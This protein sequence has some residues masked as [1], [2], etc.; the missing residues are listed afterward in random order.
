MTGAFSI[1]VADGSAQRL[2]AWLGQRVSPCAQHIPALKVRID[3]PVA[4][5][6]LS[7]KAMR[8]RPGTAARVFAAIARAGVNVLAIAQSSDEERIAVCL[9]D[10]KHARAVLALRAEACSVG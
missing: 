10:A 3:A 2:E 7:S 1:V 9:A 4:V 5:V 6:T 8:G